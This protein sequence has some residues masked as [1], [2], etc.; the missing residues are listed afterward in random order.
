MC[1][2]A[3]RRMAGSGDGDG[4]GYASCRQC[5]DGL[6]GKVELPTDSHATAS[7]PFLK[8]SEGNSV[9]RSVKKYRKSS[10]SGIPIILL[11]Q[12][13]GGGGGG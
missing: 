10:Y 12:R 11:F 7:K 2:C 13:G 5:A 6:E 3:D 8:E 9:L 1:L 4:E